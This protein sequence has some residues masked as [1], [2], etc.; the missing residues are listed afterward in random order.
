MRIP[1]VFSSEQ[2][3]GATGENGERFVYFERD[4]ADPLN[5]AWKW[6][7]T[8]EGA[9]NHFRQAREFYKQPARA[10]GGEA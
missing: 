8:R 9:E 1:K 6:Y 10:Q 3:G 7:A 2:M 4:T 5:S